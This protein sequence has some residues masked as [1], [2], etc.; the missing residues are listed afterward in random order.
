MA[1]TDFLSSIPIIGGI[2]SAISTGIGGAIEMS[3]AEK[4][5]K[6]A[7]KV[8][9]AALATRA[10]QIQPEFLQK[11]KMDEIAAA[12]GLPGLEQEKSALDTNAM[13]TARAIRE[14]SPNGAATLAAIAAS[15][16]L[17]NQSLSDLLAKNEQYRAGAM[18]EVG[19]TLQGIGGEKQS[20]QDKAD[21]VKRA[22]LQAAS[23]L[24]AAAT[25]NKMNAL[26]KIFGGVSST[27]SFLGKNVGGN[28]NLQ[29]LIQQYLSQ[30]DT[31]SLGANA[32]LAGANTGSDTTQYSDLGVD[33]SLQ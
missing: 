31:S 1:A 27:A 13:N 18:K 26:N 22:G 10:Q 16:G 8:R 32:A 23:G 11:L 21:A 4:Q 20:L 17:E 30:Q 29:K 2:A 33:K 25:Y 12:T 15:K 3:E 19:N 9:Q 7:E 5:R 6:Q 24:E 28:V 14:T